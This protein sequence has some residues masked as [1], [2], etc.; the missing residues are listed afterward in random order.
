MPTPR[1]AHTRQAFLI[2]GLAIVPLLLSLALRGLAYDDAY[3][4]YRYAKNI[5]TGN[6]FVYNMGEQ[7][8]GTTTPL[9]TLLLAGLGRLFPD[10]P[11]L[12]RLI[13]TS[14]WSGAAILVYLSGRRMGSQLGGLVGAALVALSPLVLSSLGMETPLYVFLFAGALFFYLR[15]SLVHCTIFL[16]LLLLTRGDGVLLAGVIG[17]HYTWRHRRIPWRPVALYLIITAPWFIYSTLTF[18]SPFPNSLAAK[19]GQATTPGL[20]DIG[21]R[22]G[23]FLAGLGLTA[24]SLVDDSPLYLLAIPMLLISLWPRRAFDKHRLI[25]VGWTIIY[26]MGYKILGVVR[27]P[28][29]YVPLIPPLYL[30]VGLGVADLVKWIEGRSSHTILRYLSAT[31]IS[32]ALIGGHLVSLSE[33]I[34][35]QDQK[36]EHYHL[37][38][39]WLQQNSPPDASVVTIEI[40][41]IG[42]YSERPIIDPMG[43]VTVGM[44]SHLQSWVQTLQYAVSRYT[45]AYAVTLPGTAWDVLL[46]SEWFTEQYRPV[47]QIGTTTIHQRTEEAPVYAPLQEVSIQV[48]DQIRVTGI[49]LEAE[50][51]RPGETLRLVLHWQ[52]GSPLDEDYTVHLALMDHVTNQV[53]AKT[54][55]TPM[56]GGAP[57][58]LWHVREDIADEHYLSVPAE[59]PYGAYQLLAG[60][61]GGDMVPI[62]QLKVS[63][64]RPL[65]CSP[66]LEPFWASFGEMVTLTG[67]DLNEGSSPGD[68]LTLDL[69]WQASDSPATDY[70]VFVHL[71]NPANDLVAQSDSQPMGGRYPLSIWDPGE[72][73]PDQIQISLP[74]DLAPAK[75]QLLIGLYD[76]RTGERLPAV[77]ENGRRWPD[78]SVPLG[79][80][81]SLAEG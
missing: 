33:Q 14:S 19:M 60:F 44:T 32:G 81:D 34:P 17:I 50:P 75:Y 30:L 73:V 40:G 38:G 51:I 80:V 70:A 5:L 18:G 21:G 61:G 68:T 28:W 69:C 42:Y 78:D 53:W 31:L 76:W 37:A 29:Y 23:S 11:T 64:P 24:R 77:D 72:T 65:S 27:F 49:Q 12:S 55:G 46:A 3:I 56:H 25:P 57:T 52:T 45:P 2:A 35:A 66:G 59:A 22:D 48:E 26:L 10:I 6:G 13:G 62:A 36:A 41:I 71:L 9:Y 63:P 58:T 74:D 15:G 1:P 16:A 54:S 47:A 7:V 43:L 67:I 39:Q 4:T 79:T 8:L 20:G